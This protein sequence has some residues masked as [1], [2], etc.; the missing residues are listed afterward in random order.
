MGNR[1]TT[2]APRSPLGRSF[3]TFPNIKLFGLIR[4]VQKH[5]QMHL[6][7]PVGSLV[8]FASVRLLRH[9]GFEQESTVH[10]RVTSGRGS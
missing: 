9:V 8:R 5:L 7:I 6:Q 2:W 1:A 3:V 10:L 4:I